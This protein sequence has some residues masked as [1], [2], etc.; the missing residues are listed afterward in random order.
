MKTV[1]I[2]ILAIAAGYFAWLYFDLRSRIVEI[3]EDAPVD[4]GKNN[5]VLKLQNH[6]KPFVKVKDGKVTI[7]IINDNVVRKNK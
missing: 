2:I 7:K 4:L 3:S 6:L 5:I 1:L